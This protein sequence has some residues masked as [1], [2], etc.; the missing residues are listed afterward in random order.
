[1]VGSLSVTP[2]L[3]SRRNVLASRGVKNVRS[4]SLMRALYDLYHWLAFVDL[5][6]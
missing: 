6:L 3:V 5:Y 4:D 1:M 2:A